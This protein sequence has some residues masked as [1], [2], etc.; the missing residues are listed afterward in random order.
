MDDRAVP[1]PAAARHVHIADSQGVKVGDGPQINLFLRPPPPGP[2][3][4]GNVPQIP[5]A[6]QPRED[7]MIQLRAAGPGVS[8]VR[9]VTGMRGVGKTQLAAAYARE[10]IDAGW[11]LVAWVNAEE[12]S[13]ILSELAVVADRMGIGKRGTDLRIVAGEVR[14]HLEADGDKCLLVYDNVTDTGTVSAYLPCA[15]KSQ[16][17]VTSSQA[18]AFDLGRLTQV[19]V[20]TEDQSLDFLTE[21]TRLNDPTGARTLGEELG[22]LPLALA[23][24]AAVVRAQRLPYLVYLARLRSYPVRKYLHPAA[25]DPYPHGAAE[26][27]L[28]SLDA[29]T[30]TDPT[31]LCS[32]LLSSI[33]LLSPH[34]TSRQILYCGKSRDVF[35]ADEEAI[36]EALAR[37]SDAS[38]LTFSSDGSTVTAHRLV[39]RVM[40]E[41]ASHDGELG[42]LA[43]KS[44]RLLDVY[45][46]SLGEAWQR[47]DDA[48]SFVHQVTALCDNLTN[49]QVKAYGEKQLLFLRG[50][51]LTWMNRL[52]DNPAQAI[53]IGRKLLSHWERI[54]GVSHRGILACQYELA[55]AYRDAGEAAEAIPLFEQVTPAFMKLPGVEYSDILNSINGLALAYED[56][57]R[58]EQAIEYLKLGLAESERLLGDGHSI[59]VMTRNNLAAAYNAAGRAGDA[60]TLLER[61]VGQSE[62]TLGDQHPDTQAVRCNLALGYENVGRLDD[63]ISLFEVVVS[64]CEQA[65]GGKHGNTLKA[66]FFLARPYWANGRRE[67]ATKLLEEVA[68]GF[69]RNLG[70][71]HPDTIAVRMVLSRVGGTPGSGRGESSA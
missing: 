56:V 10:C 19:D 22:H 61:A 48:R 32:D 36:D 57:G 66:K 29:T 1:D 47:R 40:R 28:L 38:L 11:R 4:A 62:R 35:M 33:S 2:V 52:G 15:G 31:G 58:R 20:F 51:S 68:A 70:A 6:F 14:N 41:R 69:D 55:T 17:V 30:A 24:A 25:G 71:E 43:D 3:V 8:V 12:I 53:E 60:I 18:T 50:L 65:L 49:H 16:V 39:M 45:A 59:T 54:G 7:L 34:G 67:E 26:A 64:A 42:R 37:L 13:S 44:C 23:Q 27:I 5:P 63:A 21:R 46:E 9:A